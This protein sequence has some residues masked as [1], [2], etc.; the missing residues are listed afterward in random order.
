MKIYGLFQTDVSFDFKERKM[1]K[2]ES[3]YSGTFTTQLMLLR[4]HKKFFGLNNL[5]NLK[6][7]R[8]CK[9]F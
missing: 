6:K 4:S 3:P 1:R 9:V 5:T 7:L 8:A 2:R